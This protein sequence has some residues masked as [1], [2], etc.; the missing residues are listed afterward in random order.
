MPVCLVHQ[1]LLAVRYQCI[2]FSHHQVSW[3]LLTSQLII[4]ALCILGGIAGNPV[5]V[6][7]EL[8]Q[9]PAAG[10]VRSTN[11]PLPT[12]LILSLQLQVA[13]AAGPFIAAVTSPNQTMS[14]SFSSSPVC[15]VC[16]LYIH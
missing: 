12:E 8:L 9:N 5:M 13:G 16:G 14:P 1:V 15:N 3:L 6:K 4:T 11:C 10:L 7:Q 2:I